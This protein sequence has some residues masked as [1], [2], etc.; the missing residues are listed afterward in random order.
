M[1]YYQ[2]QYKKHGKILHNLNC[3]ESCCGNYNFGKCTFCINEFESVRH[4]LMCCDK[5]KK[6]RYILYCKTMKILN[7]YHLDFS[8]LNL[9][10]PVSVSDSSHRKLIFHAVC[11]YVLQ[12]K[13]IYFG[14]NN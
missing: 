6:F 10:F 8:L 14:L 7:H 12:T 13:R 4:F 3:I 1:Q 11:R 2:N 5:Y 9:L